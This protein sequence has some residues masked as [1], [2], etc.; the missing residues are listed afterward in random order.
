FTIRSDVYSLGLLFYELFTSKKAFEAATLG[1]LIKL[2]R[3]NTSP[4]T[5]TSIVKDL[6]PIIERVIDRCI[7]KDPAERP[8]SA[9]QVAAAL[10]GGDPIAAA[11]AAGETP[12]PEMVAAAPKEG[13][14][15]PSIA[16]SMFALIVVGLALIVLLADKVVLYGYVPLDKSPDVLRENARDIIRR[17]GV[18]APATDHMYA[19]DQDRGPLEYIARTDMRAER[20]QDLNDG[21]P[22]VI[23]YWYRQSPSYLA[24]FDFFGDAW[25]NPPPIVSGM[26]GVKLDTRGRLLEFYTVPPQV[27]PVPSSEFRVSSS[28]QA[29]SPKSQVSSSK[30]AELETRNS[31]FETTAAP[32]WSPL[33]AAAGLD[34]S[35]LKPTTSQWA[36]LYINDTRAAWDGV[37]P[38]QPQIPIRIEAAAYRGKP[39]H[40]KIINPWDKPERQEP[41]G[42]SGQ[43]QAL[44]TLILVVFVL[45]L[46]GSVVL[47]IRNLRLGRG[48]RKGALRLAIFVFTFTLLS[49][50][51]TAHHIPT[52]GEF[53]TVLNGLQDSLFAAAFFWVVYMAIEPFVRRRSPHRIISWSRLLGGDFRDPLVGRDIL[54]GALFGVAIT[55]WQLSF[56]FVRQWLDSTLG[57]SGEPASVKLGMGYFVQALETQLNTPLVNQ[58]LLLFLILLLSLILRRDWLGF[59]AGWL[60]FTAALALL[61]GGALPNWIS[62]AVTAGLGIFVLYRY[63]LLAAMFAL[64]FLHMYI[65][66]PVTTNFTAWYATGFVIDLIILL[67]LVFYAFRTSLAG[68]P[69]TRGKFLQDV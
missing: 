34:I 58:F 44:F 9:L 10:P 69:L 12:S 28:E 4:T 32:D 49:R 17:A 18:V 39:V 36:P 67:L 46:I 24:G 37:Y 61:W 22:A 26:A 14:L 62:A 11:L 43:L 31:T 48:D 47:A 5:P 2:R 68:Q 59:I 29:S 25:T 30:L 51:F 50:I 57:P 1:E 7:Q 27:D 20:W 63:G 66:F 16:V 54:I 35:N 15:R 55:L 56:F 52:F 6:D 41:T 38:E 23:V 65:H 8:S 33:F 53:G 21:Q 45:V 3:S 13:A 40:F 60:V 42:L 19:F 64:L